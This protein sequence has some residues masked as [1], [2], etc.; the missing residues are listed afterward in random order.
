MVSKEQ[1]ETNRIKKLT[2]SCCNTLWEN[3]YRLK[4]HINSKT[5]N[6]D[7]VQKEIDK[8]KKLT[9]D[10]CGKTWRDS[11]R[12]KTHLNTKQLTKENRK[13]RKDKKEYICSICDL[14]K[15]NNCHLKKH[16]LTC[17]TRMLKRK[18]K[19]ETE[20][21]EEEKKDILAQEFKH[22]ITPKI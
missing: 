20:K 3:K 22:E 1:K 2:C 14:K 7:K 17:N 18:V 12:L 10:C 16:L 9:C 5:I 6:E 11:F 19:Q 4:T 15:I 8:I 21:V 13:I